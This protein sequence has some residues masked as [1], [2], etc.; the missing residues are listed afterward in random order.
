MQIAAL[1][2]VVPNA[3]GILEEKALTEEEW[4]A[5]YEDAFPT[6]LDALEDSGA[7]WSRVRISWKWIEEEAPVEGMPPIYEW[8][9]YHDEKLALVAGTGVQLIGTI[10]DVP[11]WAADEPFYDT[12]SPIRADRLDEFARFLTDLVNRY[13]QPPWN[14]HVWELRN[15]PDGTTPDRAAV[16]QGCG[17]LYGDKYAQMAAVAYPAIKAADPTA[18]VLMGGVAYDNFTEYGGPFNR[19]FPD[20]MMASGGAANLDAITLHYFADFAAEWER[21]VPHG[22]PPTCGLVED[23]DG[24][25]YDAW[26]IDIIAKANHFR[27][28]LA[29]C[30]GVNKPLWI[31]ELAEH[32][33]PGLPATLD[34]Q[35]RYVIQ[36]HVR[37]LAVGAVN[38]TW[39]A[40]VS[41]PYDPSE[42]G[43][44]YQEVYTPKPAYYAY[45]TLTSELAGYDYVR[46]QSAQNAEG[47]VFRNAQG[48]EKTVAWSWGAA[49]TSGMVDF[50]QTNQLRMVDR[51][52]NVTLIQ[53][54][55]AGDADGVANGT[56]VVRLPT[57]PLPPDSVL[58]RYT[59]EPYF[60]SK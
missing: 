4:L 52:G 44:L 34:Q 5:L 12:C 16:G 15:E 40:L 28:R 19:Y 55:G 60:F 27:N 48:Q 24:T 50:A 11:D 14:I 59:A 7:C 23:H 38:I 33:Y 58:P 51:S 43:L 1:H 29:V 46:P 18:T 36:G 53:D 45:Q 56:V 32:G 26:G 8:G 42:Q 49:G 6:L 2:Q 25:P 20:N 31:T 37:S 35:A 21:W 39:F 22:D 3:R 57:V 30:H 9:P 54:G 41:P 17:G 10:D 47:Y 13:K